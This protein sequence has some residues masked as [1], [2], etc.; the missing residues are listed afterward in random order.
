MANGNMQTPLN[1]AL[2]KVNEEANGIFGRLQAIVEK[3]VKGKASTID[4]LEAAEA[5]GLQITEADFRELKLDRYVLV[6][7][8]LHWCCWFPWR[9]L[10]CWWWKRYHPWYICCRWW[11]SRCHYYHHN[12]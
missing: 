11:W 5:A 2:V 1:E 8:W 12:H 4:V 7:P 9:P 6:H 10:W 3:N